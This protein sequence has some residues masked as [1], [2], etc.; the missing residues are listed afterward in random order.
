MKKYFEPEMNVEVFS[1]EDV[2]T[3]SLVGDGSESGDTPED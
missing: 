3:T 2:V 1:V